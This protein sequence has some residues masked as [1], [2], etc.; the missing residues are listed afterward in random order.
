VSTCARRRCAFRG[1]RRRAVYDDH[2]SCKTQCAKSHILE[3]PAYAFECL[4]KSTTIRIAILGTAGD[5]GFRPIR[6]HFSIEIER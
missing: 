1:P 6:Q 5:S 3:R 2:P 4:A